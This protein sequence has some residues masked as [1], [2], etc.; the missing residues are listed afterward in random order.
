MINLALKLAKQA[1]NHT[2]PNPAVGC[3]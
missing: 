2:S 1:Q 3:V